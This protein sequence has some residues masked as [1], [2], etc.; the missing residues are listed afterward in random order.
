MRL[1]SPL[2]PNKVDVFILLRA[3][4]PLPIIKLGLWLWKVVGL[5]R[6][7]FRFPTKSWYLFLRWVSL[8][9]NPNSLCWAYFLLTGAIGFRGIRVFVKAWLCFERSYIRFEF[10]FIV[11]CNPSIIYFSLS[12]SYLILFSWASDIWMLCMACIS[13]LFLTSIR[14]FWKFYILFACACFFCL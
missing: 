8:I 2:D 10:S 1:V 6:E 14:L 12:S 3:C 7:F 5:M 9:E 11:V 4:L 13:Q